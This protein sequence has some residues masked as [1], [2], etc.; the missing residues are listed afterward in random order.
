MHSILH[1]SLSTATSYLHLSS[2]KLETLRKSLQYVELIVIDE[3]SMVG[4]TRLYE[5]H[6]RFQDIMCSQ[7]LFGGKSVLLLGDIMQL[8]PVYATPIFQN[9]K[10]DDDPKNSALSSSSDNLWQSFEVV[11]LKNNFRQRNS[12]SWKDCLNRLR[13]GEITESDKQLLE[14][15][16]VKNYPDK[17]FDS[18]IHLYFTNEE[19]SQWNT[20]LLN[21]LSSPLVQITAVTIFPKGTILNPKGDTI[22]TTNLMK[23]L[24]LKIGA[25]VMLVVNISVADSLFNG[26]IGHVVGYHYNSKNEVQ[27]IMV[28]FEDPDAGEDQRKQYP[29]VCAKFKTAVPIFKY[30]AD[31]FKPSVRRNKPHGATCRVIQFPLKLSWAITGHKFQGQ[32]TKIG[33]D[34]VLHG[35]TLA[36]KNMIYVML[37]RSPAI[38]NVFIDDSIFDTLLLT[39]KFKSKEDDTDTKKTKNPLC[40][41]DCLAEK[42]RLDERSIVPELRQKTYHIFLLNIRSLSKHLQDLKAD[43]IA[44]QSFL[45]CLTETWIVKAHSS[46]MENYVLHHHPLNDPKPGKGA[47]VYR[48]NEMPFRYEPGPTWS[49]EDFQI[50]TWEMFEDVQVFLVYL[51]QNQHKNHKLLEYI[52]KCWKPKKLQIVLGDFNV[53]PDKLRIF[54]DFLMPMGFKQIVNI[55][56]HEASHTLDQVYIHPQLIHRIDLSTNCPYYSDHSAILLN[57]KQ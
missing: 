1:L 42:Q 56:T 29:N 34:L 35:N 24:S 14:A 54:T 18:A 11:V 49:F 27:A 31:Y 4:S 19:V 46:E 38:E 44:M 51:S 17:C 16:K 23:V 52:Q 48:K 3:F 15:R 2:E 53:S 21:G 47:A 28:E 22:H 45:I 5:I 40:D 39:M 7:D 8:P 12:S 25:K 37:S 43:I 13:V 41:A 50:M 36:P 30:T 26:S 55:P 10:P 57:L 32:Q 20:R 6:R 33:Q 9:P